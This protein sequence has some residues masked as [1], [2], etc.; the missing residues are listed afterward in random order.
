MLSLI[1]FVVVLF[2]IAFL[3]IK[4]SRKITF[5]EKRKHCL[6][7]LNLLDDLWT[8]G[9]LIIQTFEKLLFCFLA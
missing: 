9:D 2:K 1:K 3:V 8:K 6:Q 5:K 4:P 7:L